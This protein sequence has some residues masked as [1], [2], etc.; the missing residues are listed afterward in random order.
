MEVIAVVVIIAVLG[1]VAV[2]SVL[3]TIQ[4]GKKGSYNVVIDNIKTAAINLYEEV[5]LIGNEIPFYK[6]D[7]SEE[8]DGAGNILT[9]TIND[10]KQII[11]NL[12]TLLSNGF[13]KGSVSEDER[14]ENKKNMF[15][16][17]PMTN[18]D[19]GGCEI[20]IQKN[21]DSSFKVNYTV[22]SNGEE[23]P[24]FCPTSE[25]YQNGVE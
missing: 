20:V 13:L 10:D 24:D 25:E 21:V 22:S 4:N 8:L 3:N 5:D 17:N 9:V 11:V 7:G 18:D 6:S 16:L 12:Q 2:P 23:V 14:A 19:M 1:M 15:L